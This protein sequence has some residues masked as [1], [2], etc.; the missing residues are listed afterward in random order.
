MMIEVQSHGCLQSTLPTFVAVIRSLESVTLR[1]ASYCFLSLYG[2]RAVPK[3]AQ[4]DIRHAAYIYRPIGYY[5]NNTFIRNL[6]VFA[7]ERVRSSAK[8]TASE[9][10]SSWKRH[11]KRQWRVKSCGAPG[12]R[13]KRRRALLA[14]LLLLRL[15]V[16]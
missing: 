2:K 7:H 8:S 9:A 13:D 11:R 1:D 15:L 16:R 14:L 5:S 4:D 12:Q 10:N 6:E 3:R